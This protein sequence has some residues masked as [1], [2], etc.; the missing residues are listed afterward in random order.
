[1]PKGLPPIRGSENQ[2]DFMPSSSLPNCLA[3][4]SNLEESKE[5]QRQAIQL[6]DK[7]LV[8]ESKSSCLVL[9]ILV[10]KKDGTW[11]MCMDCWPINFITIRYRH[12]IPC[13]DDFL[14]ELY[15]VCVCIF[16]N[17]FMKWIS[18]DKGMNGKLLSKL[19]SWTI[20]MVVMPFR[21][22]NAPS[23]FMRL[24]NHVLR[25]LIGKCV[26][27]YFDDI[28][29]CSKCIDD[30]ILHVK[31]V[32]LLL[33]QECLYVSLEKCTLCIFEVVF[34]GYVVGSKGV[35]VDS[36]KVKA[37]KNWPAP[38]IIGEVRSFHGLAS[39]YRCFV[40]EFSTLSSPLNEIV[41]E[42][43]GFKWEESE[44]RDFQALKERLPNASILALPNFSKI[45]KLECDASNVEVGAILLQ[46]GHPMAYF[47][48]KLKSAQLNFSTYDKE[49]Y[50]LI[51]A[52]Q[53]WQHYLLPKEF[54]IHNDR[55]ALKHLRNQ[56]NLNK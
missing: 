43:I 51:R 53:V 5:I 34:L 25:S 56:N 21:L 29:V 27:V 14:D 47:S 39:S 54:V 55:E 52:L 9:V 50:A 28:L 45:F 22:T 36:E 24:M 8:R 46:E 32:L 41:K 12:S 16:Q 7:G 31:S 35:K 18:L 1:M 48:E 3:Y 10:P 30:H 26:V 4:S 2:I 15:G 19:K 13:L 17:R 38:K 11:C 20:W 44:E 40:K 23:T 42:N 49:L 37:I 6:L 33:K